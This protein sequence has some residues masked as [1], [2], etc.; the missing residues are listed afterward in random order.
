MTIQ[1]Y[2]LADIAALLGIEKSR[3]KNWTIGR[4]FSIQPS[5]RAS[6]G[7]GSRNLFSRNDVYCF[8]LVQRL[9]EAGAKSADIQGM[10][11]KLK[12]NL[13][14]DMFWKGGNWLSLKRTN[15]NISCEVTEGPQGIGYINVPI[16]PEDEVV[17]SYGVNL[18]SIADHVSTKI[19]MFWHRQDPSGRLR[20]KDP[21][22][23]RFRVKPGEK[24]EH[25]NRR[26]SVK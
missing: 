23:S 7:K 26:K 13:T 1:I 17:C 19:E 25:F 3:V 24:E 20:E 10:L 11:E 9:S 12:P 5:V 14:G 4:P 16:E 8:A 21:S 6:F 18:K 15:R 22:G 2:E